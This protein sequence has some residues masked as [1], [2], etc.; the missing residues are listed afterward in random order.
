[1]YR[2]L[3]PTRLWHLTSRKRFLQL[4]NSRK[5]QMPQRDQYQL[6]GL[7]LSSVIGIAF[8]Y[9]VFA[10]KKKIQSVIRSDGTCGPEKSNKPSC[11]PPKQPCME[12]KPKPYKPCRDTDN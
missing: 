5:D 1:M 10:E 8:T 12:E 3:K 4:L 2:G 11:K 6:F 9:G 7:I